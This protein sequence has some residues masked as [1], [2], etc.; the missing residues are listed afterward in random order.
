[1]RNSRSSRP[2]RTRVIAS[3][4]AMFPRTASSQSGNGWWTESVPATNTTVAGHGPKSRQLAWSVTGE[5]QGDAGGGDISVRNS[6]GTVE[7]G[8]SALAEI[9]IGARQASPRTSGFRSVCE[10]TPD[11]ARCATRCVRTHEFPGR[12]GTL[13][14]H[15]LGR[16][17]YRSHESERPMKILWELERPMPGWLYQG[18]KVVAG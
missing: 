8:P 15:C 6:E 4:C 3:A 9:R 13:P 16:A 2:R 5:T 10:R 11:C 7:V 14:Y 1:M 12:G 17:R 18:G